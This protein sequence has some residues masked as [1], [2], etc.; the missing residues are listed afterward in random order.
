LN[1]DFRSFLDEVLD[2]VR[3]EYDA[4]NLPSWPDPHPGGAEPLDEEYSR[5]TNADRYRIVHARGRAWAAVLE[6]SLG[7]VV[8]TVDP[9]D[10][11]YTRGVRVSSPRPG[12][13]PLLILEHDDPQPSL[14]VSVVDPSWI[15]THDPYCGCDACADGS[16]VLLEAIDTAIG[17][18][19]VGPYVHIRGSEWSSTWHPSGGRAGGSPGHPGFH[20][21]MELSQRLAAGE[22]VELPDGAVAIVSQS[23]LA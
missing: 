4:L 10:G 19:L 7:A 13:L 15:V 1:R 17:S 21:L 16:E 20:D 22:P 9:A 18:F 5:V 6:R 11:Q 2:L 8:E 23:W 12:A 3:A 14:R